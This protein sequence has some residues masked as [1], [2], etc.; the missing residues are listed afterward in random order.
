MMKYR[1]QFCEHSI[2]NYTS[3]CDLITHSQKSQSP[4]KN[5]HTHM[6][7]Y[8]FMAQTNA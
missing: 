8:I 4:L 3:K 6:H 7:V 2:R 5:K 1:V